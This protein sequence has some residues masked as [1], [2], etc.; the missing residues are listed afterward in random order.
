MDCGSIKYK[1]ILRNY[2]NSGFKSSFVL[3][4]NRVSVCCYESGYRVNLFHWTIYYNFSATLKEGDINFGP[5][6]T[7]SLMGNYVYMPVRKRSKHFVQYINKQY[8]GARKKPHQDRNL[9]I[10]I[11]HLN[12]V[13]IFLS[14]CRHKQS[15]WPQRRDGG[16][17]PCIDFPTDRAVKGVTNCWLFSHSCILI[18]SLTAAAQSCRARNEPSRSFQGIIRGPSFMTLVSRLALVS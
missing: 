14:K 5:G 11:G 2:K 13:T 9:Q 12:S 8:T 15:N 3:H 18:N 7:V 10:I 16:R 4:S 6:L 17:Y 1:C